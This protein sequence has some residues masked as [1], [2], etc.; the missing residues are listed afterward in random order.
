MNR[1]PPQARDVRRDAETLTRIADELG[2]IASALAEMPERQS[3]R[4]CG[5]EELASRIR[6]YLAARRARETILGGPWFAD[7]AWDLMLDLL[8]CEHEGGRRVSVSSAC[9]AAAVPATTGLRWLARLVEEGAI[10]R[11][12]DAN[13]R[14]RCHVALSPAL[15]RRLT[16]WASRHL[17]PAS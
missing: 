11:Q 5:S 1:E 17:P 7:P 16:E 13:D 14:R 6:A 10:V 4:P 3:T 9:I 2:A 15:S 12:D 8:A